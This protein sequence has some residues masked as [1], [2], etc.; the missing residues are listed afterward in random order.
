MNNLNSIENELKHGRS[1]MVNTKGISMRPLL[2]QG[3][4]HVYISPLSKPL[5]IGDLPLVKL[6]PGISRL[7]RIVKMDETGIFTRGDNC[8]ALEKV[9]QESIIGVVTE[10]YC[11]N[12]KID[13]EGI[14]YRFYTAFWLKTAPIRIFV[15]LVRN[16]IIGAI[17][18]I[19]TYLRKK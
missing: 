1:V 12:K 3:K 4:T 19:A 17:M 5:K 2:W 11:G 13:M 15:Y 8:V 6:K 9:E 18:R 14:G 10:I 16:K 7:H